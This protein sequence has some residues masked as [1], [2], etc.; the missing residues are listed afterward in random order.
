MNLLG[1][2][3]ITAV[4]TAEILPYINVR[5]AMRRVFACLANGQA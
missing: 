1:I 3:V 4:Q 5:E 2:P